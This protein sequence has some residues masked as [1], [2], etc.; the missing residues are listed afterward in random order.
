M[1]STVWRGSPRLHI[2]RL[3]LL[4]IRDSFKIGGVERIGV[5][6]ASEFQ[7]WRWLEPM[8]KARGL[9]TPDE[10]ALYEYKL[11][12]PEIA[13]LKS[14]LLAC[15]K[16]S[17]P[18]RQGLSARHSAFG[19]PI[20]FNAN[21]RVASGVGRNHWTRSQR[22][23]I[24]TRARFLSPKAWISCVAKSEKSTVTGNSS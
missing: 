10:R 12:E 22:L 3:T 11:T 14:V 1:W 23:T 15:F 13:Q 5:L 24:R 19:Q 2:P 4:R 20:G 6:S 21:S 16:G 7:A 9:A 17:L 8:L 18:R